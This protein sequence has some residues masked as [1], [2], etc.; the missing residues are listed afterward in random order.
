MTRENMREVLRAADIDFDKPG[1][2]AHLPLHEIAALVQL[3]TLELER[4]VHVRQNH[5]ARYAAAATDKLLTCGECREELLAAATKSQE[6]LKK[7]RLAP[8]A[9]QRDFSL[10]RDLYAHVFETGST[11]GVLLDDLKQERN[12]SFP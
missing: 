2:T 9:E 3:H 4:K 8:L 12:P 7:L 5:V 6:I 10:H 1:D 11:I